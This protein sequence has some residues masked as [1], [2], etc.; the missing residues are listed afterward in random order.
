MWDL[1][2]PKVEALD[3]IYM[4]SKSAACH[5]I[6]MKFKYGNQQ[7]Q[8]IKLSVFCYFHTL[9]KHK[10][11]YKTAKFAEETSAATLRPKKNKKTK[12]ICEG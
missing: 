2:H 3:Y 6:Y 5:G 4:L 10:N 12:I 1:F 11:T 8:G 7:I 9:N